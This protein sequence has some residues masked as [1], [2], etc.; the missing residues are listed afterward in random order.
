MVNK[1]LECLQNYKFSICYEN[2][3][4][5]PGYITEKIFDSMAAGCIPVYWGAPNIQQYVPEEC[6]V[7]RRQFKSDA[8]LV[9]YLLQMR[10]SEYDSRLNA[11][12]SYLE[13]QAHRLFEPEAVAEMVAHDIVGHAKQYSA[14]SSQT[15][16]GGVRAT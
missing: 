7:D 11:I 16:S 2:A 4:E 1:K 14:L 3:K 15:T 6:F 9:S 5:I 12:A 10:E 8:D 13:S